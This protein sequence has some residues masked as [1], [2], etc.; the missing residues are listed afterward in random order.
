MM[1]IQH[2]ICFFE[3]NN[4]TITLYTIKTRYLNYLMFYLVNFIVRL[5]RISKI[6]NRISKLMGK[7]LMHSRKTFRYGIRVKIM[8]GRGKG[9]FIIVEKTGIGSENVEKSALMKVNLKNHFRL[10]QRP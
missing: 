9:H 3:K 4:E 10:R 7:E 6:P 8:S 2:E 1:S 5:L